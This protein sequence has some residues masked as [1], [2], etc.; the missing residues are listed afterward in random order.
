MNPSTT[1]V[2]SVT[3]MQLKRQKKNHEA[4]H[5]KLKLNILIP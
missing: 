3:G 2:Q 5:Q 4:L 1:E